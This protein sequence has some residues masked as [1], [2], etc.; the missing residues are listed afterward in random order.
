MEE[1]LAKKTAFVLY[2]LLVNPNLHLPLSFSCIENW[3]QNKLIIKSN[4]LWWVTET[5]QL[6]EMSSQLMRL[7]LTINNNLYIF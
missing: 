5:S 2:Q 4:S 6:I 1:S 3:F 7:D